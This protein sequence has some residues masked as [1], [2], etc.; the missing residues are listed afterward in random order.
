MAKKKSPASPAVSKQPRSYLRFTLAQ[1]V[2]HLLMMLSFII[3]AFTGLA[4]KYPLSPVSLSLIK[5]MG[6]IENARAL[7]HTAA[8]VLILVGIYHLLE[9]GYKLFVLRVRMTM[10]PSPQ[11]ARDAWMAFAYNLGIGKMRPQMGRYTFEEK[12]EYW[13]L[14]WG[15]VVM[16]ITGF[17][18]WNPIAVTKILPGEFIP[19]AKAA[20]G[21]EAVLAVLAIIVWHLYG[22]HIKRFNKAMFNGQQTEQEMLHEH[23]LELADIKAG[24]DQT[25]VD[26][27]IIRKRQRIYFPI[28]AALTVAMLTGVYGFVTGEETALTTIP[29]REHQPVAF[30]PQTPTLLPPPLPTSTPAADAMDVAVTLTWDGSVGALFQKCTTC[31]G[32]V[33]PAKGLNLSAFVSVLEGSTDRVVILPADSA[34]SILV[35]VQQAGGHPGQFTSDELALI[36]EWIDAGAPEK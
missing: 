12:A 25:P 23:P 5:M 4:Q 28:A 17:L 10:L 6:G 29:P 3:L 19:A 11:D 32:A 35:Q 8:V 16:A 21:G 34:G 22:V 14:L 31:H 27:I 2:E 13:A 1:R 24:V 20:H 26:P 36:I 30:A 18:M 33:Q 7:H 15:T 9:I